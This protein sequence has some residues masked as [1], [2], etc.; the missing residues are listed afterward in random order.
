MRDIKNVEVI[1]DEN[2]LAQLQKEIMEFE[3][4]GQEQREVRKLPAYIET[5]VYLKV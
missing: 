2:T 5:V 1:L 4:P 3:V